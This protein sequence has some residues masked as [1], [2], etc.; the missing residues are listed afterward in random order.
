MLINGFNLTKLRLPF[1]P[2]FPNPI[3]IDFTGGSTW[4]WV[5]LVKTWKKNDIVL[6]PI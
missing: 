5:Y 3:V 2:C 6:L 1:V 4:E